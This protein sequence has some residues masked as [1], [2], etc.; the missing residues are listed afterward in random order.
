MNGPMM[1]SYKRQNYSDS[2]FA[3]GKRK[4]LNVVAMCTNIFLPWLLFLAIYTQMCFTVHYLHPRAATASVVGGF[5]L[6]LIAGCMAYRQKSRE[7]DPMW[8]TFASL[9]F[10]LAT[11]LAWVF[12]NMNFV[13]NM[14]P[15]YDMDNLNTYPAV[16]P[17]REKGQAVMDAGRAYFVDGAGIDMSKSIGFKNEDLYCVAPISYGGDQLA[18]YDFWAIGLNCCSGVSADFRCGEYNN[19]HARAG[20][21]LMHDA[22]RPFFKL[23]VEMAESA[24]NIKATHPLFFSWLQDP[25]AE[26]NRYRDDGFQYYMIGAFSFFV[27]NA[28]VVGCAAYGF[29]MTGHYDGPYGNY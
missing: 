18:T 22:Q 12:G 16:N 4:R 14:Q 25:V 20:L 28:V 23:A 15:F 5:V 1:G 29:S 27:F 13:Y 6:S 8:F 11:L 17:A 21:R 19:P 3:P 9:A 10:F 7:F 24:Y 2:V 26:L